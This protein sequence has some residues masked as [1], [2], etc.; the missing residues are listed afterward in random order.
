MLPTQHGFDE[1]FRYPEY[2]KAAVKGA[3]IPPGRHAEPE[4][5]TRK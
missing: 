1:S 4:S 2:N 5:R 3:D